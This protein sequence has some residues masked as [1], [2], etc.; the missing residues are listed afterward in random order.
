MKIRREEKREKKKGMR[1]MYSFSSSFE[2]VI[3]LLIT[4]SSMLLEKRDKKTCELDGSCC[5]RF[6]SP[7][8]FLSTSSLHRKYSSA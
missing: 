8:S 2:N 1:F 3:N 4:L 6:N 7:V 5:D